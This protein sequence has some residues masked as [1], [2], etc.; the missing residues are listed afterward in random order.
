[1]SRRDD[2]LRPPGPRRG[3]A[4]ATLARIASGR[5][6]ETL[7]GLFRRYGDTIYLPVRPWEGLYVF[8]DPQQAEHVLAR[9][10]DNYRK[11]FTYR[12]LRMML[13]DGLLTLEGSEWR[14]HRRIVQPVFSSQVIESLA[15]DMDA[16]AQRAVLRWDTS[17]VVDVAGEMSRLA[18]DVAGRA[19]FGTDLLAQAPSL[20][21]A[22]AGGQWLALLG[23]FL[24]LPG[25]PRS[26]GFARAVARRAG[27]GGV[28]QQVD[29]L[30]GRRGQQPGA[31]GA[32]G[33]PPAPGPDSGL[34]RDLLAQLTAARDAAGHGLST[35]EIRD[36]VATFLVAG[37]E[38][39]AMALTWTLALLSAYPQARQ[40]LEDEVD[41]VLGDGPADGEQLPWTTAVISEAMRL[42]PP[43][44]TLERSAIADDDVC[45]TRVP[46][47]SMVAVLPYLVH[48]NPAVWPNP[49]GF[50]P[51]RFLPG[52]PQRHRYAWIPFGGGRRA[53]VGA[54][55]AR[56]EAVLLLARIC[57]HYRLDLTGPGLPRPRGFVT[58]RPADPVRM[59]LTRRD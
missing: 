46:A 56:R 33:G 17:A 5:P 51:G 39:T 4:V 36:E 14:R 42:Y 24:P 32:A 1:M 49:A 43:A 37:H 28:Q 55:F 40:R 45:G 8:S 35:P 30:I 29:L 16:A 57:R 22:L 41:A 38:T 54:G 7:T 10:Q 44:W 58:L 11:P 13:G 9:N 2:L 27:A 59:R 12:P 19:F 26:A 20:R 6:L 31:A 3:E 50:D 47:G 53:C 23:A 21:R 15:G 18:L 34:S 52:A 25:G 48:R